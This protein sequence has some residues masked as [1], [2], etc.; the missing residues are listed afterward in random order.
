MLGE[1]WRD[2]YDRVKRSHARLLR[3]ADSLHD[4]GSDDARDTLFHFC[5]DA[6]HLKDWL[7]NADPP[8]LSNTRAV[9]DFVNDKEAMQI[10]AD[11]CNGAKHFRIDLDLERFPPR[12]GDENTAVTTQSVTVHFGAGIEHAW[13]ITSND[14]THDALE[15]AAQV[16]ADWEGWLVGQRLL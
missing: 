6:Y 4:V 10:C 9:E 12:T 16:I 13:T 7:K 14:N 1:I 2:Q 8:V 11:L 5:Q 15:L 3:T